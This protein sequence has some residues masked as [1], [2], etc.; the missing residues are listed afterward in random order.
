MILMG[1]SNEFPEFLP[2]GTSNKSEAAV[3]YCTLY[4]D[5]CSGLTPIAD[6][7][8]TEVWDLCRYINKAHGAEIIPNII[9][10]KEPSAELYEGQRDTDSLPPYPVLDAILKLYIE[11][12]EMDKSIAD[13]CKEVVENSGFK[14]LKKI[15]QMVD[16]SEFKRRQA[17]PTIRV[18]Q[19]AWGA[20]RR[21][22][23]AQRHTPSGVL[24]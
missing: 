12:S 20:G 7:Y 5:M 2:L 3:G 10:D 13:Q 11:G 24:I 19:K 15:H 17:S 16:R 8:K 22:P 14:D 9:I 18:H 6:L 23:I 21:M 4:G 1:F